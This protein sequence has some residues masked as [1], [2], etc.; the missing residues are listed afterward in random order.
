VPAP[1]R[2]R[3]QVQ[4]MANVLAPPSVA[5]REAPIGPWKAYAGAAHGHQDRDLRLLW[6]ER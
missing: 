6:A 3:R 4:T 5:S 2:G 1:A